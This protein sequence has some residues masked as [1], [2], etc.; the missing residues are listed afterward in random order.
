ME[1]S[2]TTIDVDGPGGAPPLPITSTVL[3][4]LAPQFAQL[5]A[6][7]PL[8]IDIAPT[9]A[10]IITGNAGPNGELEEL[11]V[12]QVLFDIVQPGPETV[13]LS[14]AFDARLGMNAAFLPDGSGL[15]ITITQPSTSNL[16]LT[17]LDNPLGADEAQL[18]AVLPGLIAAQLPD[19][20]GAF[21]GF[22]LPQFF[23]LSLSG[24]E[25]SRSGQF[26]SLYS[27]LRVGP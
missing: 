7:T 11:K 15:A 22:P 16:A 20:A 13:W 10:P 5:P 1:S 23:G 26:M 19:L 27:N 2:L 25:V 8:R 17:I 18:Q 3:S 4:L 6:N 21:G 24:V 14:G 12:A 9:L